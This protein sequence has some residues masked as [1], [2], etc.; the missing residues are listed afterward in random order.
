MVDLRGLPKP[1]SGSH[2]V[3]HTLSHKIRNRLAG[4]V[5]LAICL[6]LLA[7][8]SLTDKI[9]SKLTGKKGNSPT[10][11]GINPNRLVDLETKDQGSSKS[12]L[13]LQSLIA[14]AETLRAKKIATATGPKRSILVLSGGGSYG[15][16]QAGVLRGWG[17]LGGR[18]EFDVITGVSTGALVA[19]MTFPGPYMDSV[20]EAVFTSVSNKDIFKKKNILVG[21]AQGH[22]AD[23]KPLRELIDAMVND[24]Y[25]DRVAGQHATG[26][27]LY[28]GTTNLET[29]RQVIWDMGHIAMKHRTDKGAKDLYRNILQASAAIPGLFP[30]VTIPIEVGGKTYEEKHVDG[31]VTAG[32][33]L[34]PFAL[35]PNGA[36]ESLAGSDIYILVAGKLYADPGPVGKDLM[37]LG[38]STVAALLS[39]QVRDEL[40]EI[41]TISVFQGMRFHL[42][43]V[44]EANPITMKSSEFDKKQMRELFADGRRLGQTGLA[45]RDM[46]PGIQAGEEADVR[47]SNRLYQLPPESRAPKGLR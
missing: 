34:R 17:D 25:L 13:D 33:F 11:S 30:A 19:C 46:P 6:I 29:R 44:P 23:T 42:A 32:V 21:L 14:E 3:N 43:A 10:D 5:A 12:G 7:G 47:G 18:P 27:R 39:G 2:R 37:S 9:T 8:C 35:K 45:W 15:A 38:S 24:D 28:V 26:R 36:H 22:V 4:L 40:C 41:Y 16:F 31:G 1:R 20:C